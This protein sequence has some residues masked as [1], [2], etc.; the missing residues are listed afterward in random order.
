MNRI[1]M[2]VLAMR[3]DIYDVPL[4]EVLAKVTQ[5]NLPVCLNTTPCPLTID[6]RWKIKELWKNY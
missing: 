2:H 5:A 3:E 6:P 1:S 4:Q